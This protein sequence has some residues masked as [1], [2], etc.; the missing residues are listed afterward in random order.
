MDA[1]EKWRYILDFTQATLGLVS[2]NIRAVG[3]EVK[4]P[5]IFKGY[6]FI[7]TPSDETTDDIQ[8]ILEDFEA[9]QEKPIQ[10][11]AEVVVRDFDRI[12]KMKD[13]MFTYCAKM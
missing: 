4:N 3:L 5:S 12:G 10:I 2:S 13:V 9:L 11:T 6:F 8:S 7:D 1:H